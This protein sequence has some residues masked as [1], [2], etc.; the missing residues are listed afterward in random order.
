MTPK[1]IVVLNGHPGDRSLSRLFTE[2]YADAAERAGHQ[3]RLIHLH[4]LQF[5]PDFGDGGYADWKPLE[6]G[7]EAFLAH[8]EWAEHLVMSAPLWW[9]GLP[10]KLKGLFD[11]V[12]IPGRTFDTRKLK[13]GMPTPVLTGKTG[14]IILTS[15]TPRWF[16]RLVYGSAILR[17]LTGQVFGF[18]GIKPTKFTYFSGA[19]HPKPGAVDKWVAQ[20]QSIGA[21]AL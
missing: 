9:G 11:R 14:R 10:A 12:L 1:R 3:V 18:V 4:D 16:L 13:L 5:D 20:V 19:S 17:Q 7:I 2:T 8:L 21:Q 6:P 15:D